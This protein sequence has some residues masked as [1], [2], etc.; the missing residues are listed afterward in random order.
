LNLFGGHVRPGWQAEM[1]APDFIGHFV[2]P[3]GI[4]PE[5]RT[6]MQRRKHWTA[7]YAAFLQM[8]LQSNRVIRLYAEQPLSESWQTL[9]ISSRILESAIEQLVKPFQLC[10]PNGS[11][12]V[13]HPVIEAGQDVS[14][15][16][17]ESAISIIPRIP[18]I[19]A[20]HPTFP[21]GDDF[22]SIKGVASHLPADRNHPKGFTG[23]LN[24]RN[25]KL[26]K[27]ACV[28]AVEMDRDDCSGLFVKDAVDPV[29]IQSFSEGVNVNKHG[30]SSAGQDSA[31][32]SAECE[33]RN[34]DL[35]SRSDAKRE[36]RHMERTRPAAGRNTRSS[37]SLAE[38]LLKGTFKPPGMG[39]PSCLYALRYVLKFITRKI[40]LC[41]RNQA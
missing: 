41:E 2:I 13:R 27:V 17:I 5:G 10:K 36:K 8:L 37:E 19:T 12:Q 4:D 23:I 39:H 38:G 3:F 34:N 7:I 21:G 31:R 6:S 16:G 24:Y 14:V 35:I 20:E 28:G 26:R 29:L 30:A 22:V 40:R 18:E 11:L 9:R 32:G 25:A 15:L 33:I 1:P